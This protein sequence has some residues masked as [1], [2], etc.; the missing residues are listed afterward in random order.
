M[1]RRASQAISA[2]EGRLAPN[3]HPV[4]SRADLPASIVGVIP[5]AEDTLYRVHGVISL[6]GET[7]LLASGSALI[8][9]YPE[10][11]M[12]ITD[13]PIPLVALSS[14]LARVSHLSLTN[15]GGLAYEPAP[16]LTLEEVL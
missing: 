5:L 3:E 6:E 11:D 10:L 4:Y 16:G 8:G 2:A 14:G 1:R 9:R 15:L 7:L 13:S 12:I